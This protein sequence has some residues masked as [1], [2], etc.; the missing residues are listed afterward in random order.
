MKR[1]GFLKL[2]GFGASAPVAVSAANAFPK[3]VLISAT[4]SP[5]EQA[6][7]AINNLPDYDEACTCISTYGCFTAM[8]SFDDLSISRKRYKS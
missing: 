2:L 7:E 6:E 8:G 4:E 1:R 5:P 3:D